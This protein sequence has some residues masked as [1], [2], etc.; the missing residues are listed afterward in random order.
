MKLLPELVAESAARAPERLAVAAPTGKRGGSVADRWE[1][2]T[3]GELAAEVETLA[4][5]LHDFGIRPGMRTILMVRPGLDFLPLTFALF[6]IGAVP[7]LIDPGMGRGNLLRCIES[8]NAEAFIGTPLAHFIRKIKPGPFRSLKLF[9]T[10]GRR[11]LWGGETL[12]GIRKRG[13]GRSCPT[14]QPKPTDQAAIIFTTGSTGPPK[15]V[16]YTHGMFR[17]QR[18]LLQQIFGIGEGD[19]DMPGFILFAIFSL[20]MG[21]S[22]VIPEMDPTRPAEVDPERIREAVNDHGVTFSFGSPALWRTVSSWCVDRKVRFDTLRCVVMAGA[23]VPYWLHERML[24]Q[25]LPDEAQV[26][27]PY[28]ATESLPVTS[29]DGRTILAETAEATSQGKGVCV[30]KSVPG[31]ELRIV[32]VSDDPIANVADTEPLPQGEIG[33]VIVRGPNVSPEYFELPE[34]TAEH[35]IYGPD[36]EFW[37]R[38]GDVGYLDEQGRLWFC[39]RKGHRVETIDGPLYTVPCEAISNNHPDVFRSAL[40]GVGK[41]GKERPVMLVEAEPGKSV[42]PDE[43]RKLLSESPV[44]ATIHDVYVHPGFPVDIR[45]NAKIFREKLRP[46]VADRV[47]GAA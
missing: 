8:V 22:V 31:V 3:F 1:T 30:G 27:T 14:P 6:R 34:K 46:W 9:V 24:E 19:V 39:G 18:D 2:Q 40:I 11:W 33:E 20:A 44:T 41:Q 47:G 26:Y 42:T 13:N 10:I 37:H 45:H 43:I 12:V 16:C 28:G 25:V 36:G 7:V 4:A 35:K 23:P 17:A 29:I 32:R 38:I 21:L 5:G 15:G